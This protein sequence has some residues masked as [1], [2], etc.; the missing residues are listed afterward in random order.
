MY[1]IIM[2]PLTLFSIPDW[3]LEWAMGPQFSLV[4]LLCRLQ[5]ICISTALVKHFIF[6][7]FSSKIL[8][9]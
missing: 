9:R 8:Y 3:L 6:I 1:M 2:S 7:K 5:S 4:Q